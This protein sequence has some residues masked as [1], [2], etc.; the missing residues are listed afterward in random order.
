MRKI[1]ILYFALVC[2]NSTMAQ[3]DSKQLYE[4]A[5]IL[6]RQGEYETATSVLLKAIK[7]DSLQLDMQKDLA[8]LYLLQNNYASATQI[9]RPLI[10]RSDADAQCFQILGMAY[11]AV[12]NNAECATLYKYA[13]LKFP[14]SGV[15]YNDFGELL[16]K[17]NQ[18]DQ[19][20]KQ[21]ELG[22]END[23]N[24]SGNYYNASMYYSLKRQWIQVAFYGEYFINIESFTERTEA[25]KSKIV[26]AYQALLQPNIIQNSASA[27]TFE[28]A[29]AESICSYNKQTKTININID[30]ILIARA[31]FLSFWN[32]AHA[33]QYPLRLI[34]HQNQLVKEGIFEAYNQ[35]IFANALNAG[36]NQKWQASHSKE[37]KEFEQFQ[38]GR[39]FKLPQLQ[40]YF[41]K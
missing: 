22:I 17:Q 39:V 25:I 20:I 4:S 35:W 16:A 33:A 10:D 7:Q 2:C 5:K 1:F 21:W 26:N 38:T 23:P 32:G 3:Q 36:A 15:I 40:Y 41:S 19:A 37:A 9:A 14:Y 6:M 8:Y 11:K 28:K 18:L 29:L 34:D 30:T 27:S 13:I 24:Y 31:N 12:G